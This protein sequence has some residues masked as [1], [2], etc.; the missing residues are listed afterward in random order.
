MKVL[1]VSDIREHEY[2]VGVSLIKHCIELR[3]NIIQLLTI[4]SLNMI[5]DVISNRDYQY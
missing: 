1:E 2:G 4:E 5:Y 3:Y